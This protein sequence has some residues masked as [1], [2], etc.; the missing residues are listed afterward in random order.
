MGSN[1]CSPDDPVCVRDRLLNAAEVVAARDGVSSLTLEAVAREAGVSKGG[2][3]YH[4]P[5]KSALITAIVERL[6]TTCEAEQIKAIASSTDTGPGK[7][8]RA[9]LTAR[10]EPPDPKDEPIHAA[11][12]AA[13][14]TDP[15]FLEPMIRRVNEWQK[16][17][18]ND[19]I[20]PATATIVRLAIDGLCLGTLLGI[21]VP[22]G[23][24][25][26]KI[27]DQLLAMTRDQWPQDSAAP[28]RSPSGRGLG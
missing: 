3:L 2:L 24:L 17:I 6:A 13:I 8:I 10:A 22:T 4:F 9:Y 11:L 15:H 28:V 14:G 21:P 7:F 19:G 23:A 20:D 18:E 12:L 5:S 26:R 1:P 16:K 27:L 25:R